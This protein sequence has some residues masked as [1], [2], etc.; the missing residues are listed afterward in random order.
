MAKGRLFISKSSPDGWLKASLAE[1]HACLTDLMSMGTSIRAAIDAEQTIRQKIYRD[2][3]MT[4]NILCI[5]MCGV[6]HRELC[7]RGVQITLVHVIE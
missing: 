2:K 6:T 3:Y 1:I 4:R 5:F 7:H